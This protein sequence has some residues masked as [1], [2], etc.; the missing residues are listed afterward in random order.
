MRVTEIQPNILALEFRQ[1]PTDSDYG[2]CLWARFYFNLDRYELT[3]I[4]DCGEYGYKWYETEHES[5]LELM[6]RIDE[7]YLLIKLYGYPDVFDYEG[8]KRKVYE[9]REDIDKEELDEAFEEIEFNGYP[10]TE[11]SFVRAIESEIGGI[12]EPYC[13]VKK[14]Y[15]A[16]AL[17][18]C[19]VFENAIKPKIK[20]ILGDFEQ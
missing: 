10:E 19:S 2:T 9:Y 12:D 16:N 11:E 8:S 18:I 15:P 20:E 6:S 7:D 3:I 1:E 13:L 4:S 14:V 17:K 5:F